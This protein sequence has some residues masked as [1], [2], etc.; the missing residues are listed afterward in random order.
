MVIDA[1]GCKVIGSTIY[2]YYLFRI[3]KLDLYL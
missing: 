1:S 2:L 3:L